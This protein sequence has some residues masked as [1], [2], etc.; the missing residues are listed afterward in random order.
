MLSRPLH[1]AAGFAVWLAALAVSSAALHYYSS[2]EGGAVAPQA[3]AIA[4]LNRYRQPDRALVAMALHP[5]CSCSAASLAELGDLLARSR[6]A[7]DALLLEFQPA[8][9]SRDWPLAKTREL[10]GVQVRAIADPDGKFARQLG[11]LTSG[12]VV[13]VDP[14]GAIRFRGGITVSRGHRGRAPGQDAILATLG[15]QPAALASTPVYGCAL[16]PECG[17]DAAP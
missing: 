7:C 16:L 4:F 8:K 11:A 1:L 17:A 5:N 3:E 13:F 6:G 15:G 2:V 12:H 14:Q 9:D 10:G